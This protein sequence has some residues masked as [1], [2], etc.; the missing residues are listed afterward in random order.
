MVN[1]QPSYQYKYLVDLLLKAARCEVYNIG[2]DIVVQF[3]AEDLNHLNLKIQLA[4]SNAIE[5]EWLY[6]SHAA[7]YKGL[8]GY[9]VTCS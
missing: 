6:Y 4:S 7:R 1:Y 5:A 2:N 8:P 3:Y 9:S